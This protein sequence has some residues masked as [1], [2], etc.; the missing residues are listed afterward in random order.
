MD[1][2]EGRRALSSALSAIMAACAAHSTKNTDSPDRAL[3]ISI[4]FPSA[5]DVNSI[6]GQQ[7]LLHF[8]HN[9]R[10]QLRSSS[11]TALITLPP[12]I[13]SSP[14]HAALISALIH[15]SDAAVTLVS[16]SLNPLSS[17]QGIFQ[18]EKLPAYN[19]LS[20]PSD[21]LSTLR[22]LGQVG[23]G[24]GSNRGGGENNLAFRCKRRAF[25]IETLNLD[26]EGGVGERRTAPPAPSVLLPSSSTQDAPSYVEVH[27]MAKESPSATAATA[28][29]TA[30]PTKGRPRRRVTF[31]DTGGLYDF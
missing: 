3:R 28:E 14:S 10:R 27:V 15:L 19:S 23:K 8:M 21:K 6:A 1:L 11:T 26:V 12:H 24:D 16:D 9:L 18:I 22:G 5:L 2:S 7:V 20:S 4:I 30:S 13:C 25:V 31:N 17:H 29:T